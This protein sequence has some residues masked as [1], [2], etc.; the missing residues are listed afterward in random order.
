VWSKVDPNVHQLYNKS[1]KSH[2]KE[3]IWVSGWFTS[4][5]ILK[6]I[7]RPLKYRYWK[8]LSTEFVAGASGT[9]AKVFQI[10]MSSDRKTIDSF[11]AVAVE[12]FS[13]HLKYWKS[14]W[15]SSLSG[16]II[17]AWAYQRSFKL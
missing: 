1:I 13:I 12:K 9:T 6:N 3:L 11:V 2:A 16:V 4:L 17:P 10:L 15:D 7:R 14:D 8:S 5:V